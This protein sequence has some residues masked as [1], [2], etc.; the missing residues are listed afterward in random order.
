MAQKKTRSNEYA[1]GL[2]DVI[3]SFEILADPRNCR[4]KRHYF[5]EIIFIALTAMIANCYGFK[6]MEVFAKSK[7]ITAIPKLL[8]KLDLKGHTVSLDAMG[9]Q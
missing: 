4:A 9:C 5:G 6:D 1:G 8:K 2:P 3:K 7:E